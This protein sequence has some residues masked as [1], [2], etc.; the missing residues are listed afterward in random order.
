MNFEPLLNMSDP[1]VTEIVKSYKEILAAYRKIR[2]ANN[3]GTGA[4]TG[5][6]QNIAFSQLPLSSTAGISF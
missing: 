6:T 4:L 5:A 1:K 3:Y 2:P